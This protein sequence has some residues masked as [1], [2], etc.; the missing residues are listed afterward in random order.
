MEGFFYR[1]TN[2]PTVLFFRI[3]LIKNV[4][5][6]GAC[7]CFIVSIYLRERLGISLLPLGKQNIRTQVPFLVQQQNILL[8]KRRIFPI[9]FTTA[10]TCTVSEIMISYATRFNF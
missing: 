9:I 6:V 7:G 1:L 3:G 5:A 8:T 2:S 10:I 4:T